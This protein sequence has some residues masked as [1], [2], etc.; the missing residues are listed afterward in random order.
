M[1]Y[2]IH[3]TDVSDTAN[4]VRTVICIILIGSETRMDRESIKP[5]LVSAIFC[6]KTERDSLR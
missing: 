2:E 1:K 3:G 5:Y 6:Q 4:A